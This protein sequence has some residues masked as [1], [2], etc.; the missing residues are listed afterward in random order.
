MRLPSCGWEMKKRQENGVLEL[1]GGVGRGPGA[2]PGSVSCCWSR[3]LGLWPV[4]VLGACAVC[5]PAAA[6][7]GAAPVPL[8]SSARAAGGRCCRGQYPRGGRGLLWGKAGLFLWKRE[9]LKPAQPSR[10]HLGLAEL[11]SSSFHCLGGN[12]CQ[13]GVLRS[14]G[15]TAARAGFG[16]GGGVRSAPSGLVGMAP[17]LLSR[18]SSW[19]QVCGREL[20]VHSWLPLA[21][22]G[23]ENRGRPAAQPRRSLRAGSEGT[24]PGCGRSP[25]PSAGAPGL[26][27]LL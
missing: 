7:P 24:V 15:S 19:V 26:G 20:P 13:A 18:F 17:S 16:L 10:Q 25:W 8:P 12:E 23:C 27:P 6:R 4:L 9:E 3:A 22:P 21:F 2:L 11:F 5:A 1:R 14:A